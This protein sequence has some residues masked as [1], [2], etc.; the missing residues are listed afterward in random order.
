MT[1]REKALRAMWHRWGD[2][3]A[4]EVFSAALESFERGARELAL[5]RGVLDEITAQL[6]TG[7]RHF[8][9]VCETIHPPVGPGQPLLLPADRLQAKRVLGAHIKDEVHRAGE[10]PTG[11][12]MA[13]LLGEA[14]S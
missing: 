8:C 11:V 7:R 14:A 5:L 9:D 12:L 13:R 4:F 10:I 6:E 1:A 2:G 3:Y